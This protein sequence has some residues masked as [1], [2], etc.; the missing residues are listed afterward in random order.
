MQIASA[1]VPGPCH[2]HDGSAP[3][4]QASTHTFVNGVVAPSCTMPMQKPAQPSG[5]LGFGVHVAPVGLPLDATARQVPDFASQLRP[6]PQSLLL[7][8]CGWQTEPV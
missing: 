3:T 5:P 2:P 7:L 4:V 8:H 1:F 6:P